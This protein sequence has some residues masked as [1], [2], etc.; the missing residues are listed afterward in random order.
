MELRISVPYNFLVVPRILSHQRFFSPFN[1]QLTTNWIVLALN[2]S[3]ERKVI[4]HT[5]GIYPCL[6]ILTCLYYIMPRSPNHRSKFHYAL[7]CRTSQCSMLHWL[8]LGQEQLIPHSVWGSSQTSKCLD[9]SIW[10]QQHQ[11]CACQT[12]RT[13][14]QQ[15]A[16]GSGNREVSPLTV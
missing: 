7:C 9:M 14:K 4:I 3:V 12:G 1:H 5:V 10:T 16:Q 2:S 8:K 6:D 11:H 15:R 13:G